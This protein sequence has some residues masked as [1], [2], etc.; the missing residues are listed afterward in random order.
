MSAIGGILNF[1]GRPLETNELL[2]LWQLLQDRGPDG[3]D[4]TYD[5]RGGGVCYSA[6]HITSES[7]AEIQP[8]V[9]RDGRIMT[10][11]L[12]LANRDELI[13]QLRDLIRKEPTEITDIELAMA[14][15]EKWGEMFPL[16]LI[17]EFALILIDPANRTW[18]LARDHIG[19]RPLYYHANESRFICA[20]NIVALL[21]F[22]SIPQRIN[23][24][25]IADF[26]SYI[27]VPGITAFRDIHSV[28]PGCVLTVTTT[29]KI[30]ERRYWSLDPNKQIRFKN[31]ADYEEAFTDLFSKAVQATLRTDRPV[32]ADLS[33]GLD[34]SS[35]VCMSD[36]LIKTGHAEALSVEPVSLVYEESRTCDERKFIRY[37]ETH[38]GKKSNHLR[39]DD[40]PI[41]SAGA[42][43]PSIGGPSF[44]YPFSAYHLAKKRTADKLGARVILCGRGGDQILNSNPSPA[45]E[46]G[47]LLRLGKPL[48]LHQRLGTWSQALKKPYLALAWES[49][50]YPALP[51][52]LQVK[53]KPGHRS[54][55]APWIDNDFAR[56][57]NLP[58]RR[59]S[60]RDEFGFRLP[61][62]RDQV[63]GFLSVMR[64]V[65]VSHDYGLHNSWVSYPFLHR[66]LVEF[67]QAIPFNQKV[68]PGETRSLLRRSL[69]HVLPPETCGRKGKKSPMEAII[70]AL[71]RE[72][73]RLRGLLTNA[74][75]CSYG[76][77]SAE[78]LLEALD[79]A[80]LGHDMAATDVINM[81][82]LEV[83]LR[84]L[85]KH[86]RA[87]TQIPSLKKQ[88]S[89]ALSGR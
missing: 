49:L 6:F 81:V 69:R 5:G 82:C 87:N 13:P 57:M 19:A 86:R 3:G 51:L 1:D 54:V 34:S 27:P 37:V 83:W 18:I 73:I 45:P 58:E 46:L 32:L 67:M 23:E 85:E 88:L 66:P 26:L 53:C 24:E 84:A 42:A 55:P 79:R 36:Q 43:E 40:Y 47:D 9:A 25:Y 59:R 64:G 72:S 89:N 10:G 28:K 52:N 61:S 15:H 11:D 4:I 30:E 17:G 20:S 56:R 12:R 31:D 76:F 33:G 29:G 50:I 16:H 8:S 39:E 44:F 70:R 68:R 77:A 35:V 41:L 74:L 62:E 60:P 63:T 2:N 22:D 21:H 7:R 75:V 71:G 80:K 78:P 14:A 65:A 38:I 48:E